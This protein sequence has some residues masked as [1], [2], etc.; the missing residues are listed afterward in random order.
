MI[1]ISTLNK[2]DQNYM[3]K[4]NLDPKS[5]NLSLRD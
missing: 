3:Y 2:V 5:S 4:F 1:E